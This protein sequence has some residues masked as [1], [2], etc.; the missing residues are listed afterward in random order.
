M[1]NTLEN[2]KA[3]S[4]SN[5]NPLSNKT[6]YKSLQ[7]YDYFALAIWQFSLSLFLHNA[8]SFTYFEIG[9]IIAAGFIFQVGLE[10]ISGIIG[11]IFGHRQALRISANAYILYPMCYLAILIFS[12]LSDTS[13]FDQWKMYVVLAIEFIF[14]VA[15]ALQSGAIETWASEPI[16]TSATSNDKREKLYAELESGA[17]KS[18]SEGLLFG[19]IVGFLSLSALYWIDLEG[20]NFIESINYLDGTSL[21]SLYWAAPWILSTFAY[22]I[23]RVKINK[24]EEN[25]DDIP[26]R[27]SHFSSN[28]DVF[29]KGLKRITRVAIDYVL[30]GTPE[31]SNA[32]KSYLVLLTINS[33][34]YFS[35]YAVTVFWALSF[36]DILSEYNDTVNLNISYLILAIVWGLISTFMYAGAAVYENISKTA[37]SKN[38][39]FISL[40]AQ[41]IIFFSLWHLQQL[42]ITNPIF[43]LI[44]IVILGLS[45]AIE[46]ILR[47][48][49]MVSVSNVLPTN[50]TRSTLLSFE[51]W[52]RTC[53]SGILFIIVGALATINLANIWF[54][55]FLILSFGIAIHIIHFYFKDK[56]NAASYLF[57]IVLFTCA[58]LITFNNTIVFPTYTG[59]I[60]IT[61]QEPEE[62][63]Q[64]NPIPKNRDNDASEPPELQ[65]SLEL[66][67]KH[68][69]EYEYEYLSTLFI[70]SKDHSKGSL[71]IEWS[72]SS[73]ILAITRE[74]DNRNIQT[75]GLKATWSNVA[76]NQPAYTY[77]YDT[78]LP[79]SPSLV[80][81]APPGIPLISIKQE[82][83]KTFNTPLEWLSLS[84]VISLIILFIIIIF[85]FYFIVVVFTRTM[86]FEVLAMHSISKLKTKLHKL[87][88]ELTHEGSG[89]TAPLSWTLDQTT[90]TLNSGLLS[91]ADVDCIGLAIIS[92]KES[93]IA[94]IRNINNT[95]S[96]L[97][98]RQP[99]S[100]T[101]ESI[102]SDWPTKITSDNFL[103]KGH[104]TSSNLFLVY[105]MLDKNEE[106]ITT[107][108]LV[109]FIGQNAKNG[110]SEFEKEFFSLIAQIYQN[111]YQLSY[112]Y[113][114]VS[115]NEPQRPT[116]YLA[117]LEEKLEEGLYDSSPTLSSDKGKSIIEGLK[118][119]RQISIGIHSL[120]QDFQPAPKE[121]IGVPLLP[122]TIN[123]CIAG[124]IYLYRSANLI[125][126][127]IQD[128]QLVDI[129]GLD[130]LGYIGDID[131][132]LIYLWH[133]FD[134]LL[135]NAFKH[136]KTPILIDCYTNSENV[137]IAVKDSGRGI[138]VIKW[139]YSVINRPYLLFGSEDKGLFLAAESAERISAKLDFEATNDSIS[140]E[141]VFPRVK[142]TRRIK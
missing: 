96:T 127:N 48:A 16:R 74:K 53:F 90:N 126:E 137:F 95:G 133:L 115:H 117:H 35:I 119:F 140:L 81:A 69:H 29:K 32:G 44:Y 15:T 141:Y 136:G 102:S 5:E 75:L 51:A 62:K 128:D 114:S 89:R 107:D 58:L 43:I 125:D 52:V 92:H 85:V 60:H 7:F 50:G 4:Q 61:E 27:L 18:L 105:S 42:D 25:K 20:S 142:F 130:N 109:F 116:T 17:K 45:K 55:G 121:K 40:I 71:S 2:K 14:A 72:Q 24:I 28:I 31:N 108:H 63:T 3:D 23:F 131:I 87:R 26:L 47:P 138:P 1:T 110:A 79:A 132:S 123:S 73:P 36:I 124:S 38:I 9:L 83:S 122:K 134:N 30:R 56:L 65:A 84:D 139:N 77:Q 49:T 97:E 78:T 19:G 101:A 106:S 6:L 94:K 66:E 8:L 98:E 112:V 129:K 67:P 70:K 118:C 111:A 88:L 93:S 11:D 12:A 10:I 39:I 104:S 100:L 22:F 37:S 54:F 21:S 57:S 86:Q 68:K 76:N 103:T 99:L 91:N 113:F 135:R 33:F 120:F 64:A 46:G 13:S 41:A 82:K 59:S 34:A 80:T